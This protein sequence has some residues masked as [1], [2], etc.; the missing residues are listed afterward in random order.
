MCTKAISWCVGLMSDALVLTVSTVCGHWAWDCSCYVQYACCTYVS[1]LFTAGAKWTH[2]EREVFICGQRCA[3]VQSYLGERQKA[4]CYSKPPF[5]PLP[6]LLSSFSQPSPISFLVPLFFTDI[7][8]LTYSVQSVK[9]S[10]IVRRS[11]LP[12]A[13][14]KQSSSPDQ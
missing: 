4:V 3:V 2:T 5:F 8:N 10:T 14:S 6:F 1:C 13:S 11:S 7:G 9:E 12:S